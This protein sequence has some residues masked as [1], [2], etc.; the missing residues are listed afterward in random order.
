MRRWRTIHPSDW[1]NQ[2]ATR[3]G[4]DVE[5]V[6][7]RNEKGSFSVQHQR[8]KFCEDLP[9]QPRLE[10]HSR[11]I[12]QHLEHQ[13]KDPSKVIRRYVNIARINMNEAKVEPREWWEK[14]CVVYCCM[15]PPAG[16]FYIGETKY[17]LSAYLTITNP[18]QY[19]IFPLYVCSDEKQRRSVEAETNRGMLND[20]HKHYR[21]R[22]YNRQHGRHH[23]EPEKRQTATNIP[24]QRAKKKRLQSRLE[25]RIRRRGF[26]DEELSS[27]RDAL[28][29]RTNPRNMHV[30]ISANINKCEALPSR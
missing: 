5:S 25:N 14:A 30:L 18:Y 17:T 11:K 8:F 10:I 24:S 19:S 22:R 4:Y 27:R 16:K 23:E 20:E 1:T 12:N 26:P 3:S 7:C 28:R 29:R 13:R 6:Q 2:I 9:N 21:A 15:H